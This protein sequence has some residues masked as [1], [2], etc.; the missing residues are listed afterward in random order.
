MRLHSAIRTY[1]L[2]LFTQCTVA[3][4]SEQRQYFASISPTKAYLISVQMNFVHRTLVVDC[5]I[6]YSKK[7]TVRVTSRTIV[8]KTTLIYTVNHK[9]V[10]VYTF[11][12]IT[13]ENRDRFL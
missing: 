8:P 6:S 13:L 4:I 11:V 3:S 5:Y 1:Q 9:K 2:T 7:G 12:I 10:A